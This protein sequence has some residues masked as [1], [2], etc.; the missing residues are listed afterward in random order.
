MSDDLQ[1]QTYFTALID[2]DA[3]VRIE[4]ANALGAMGD[5]RAVKP[6]LLALIDEEV[7]VRRAA[8]RALGKLGDDSAIMG[9]LN[10]FLDEDG[11]VRDTVDTVLDTLGGAGLNALVFAAL[12]HNE[13][14]IRR[15]A[16]ERLIHI[17]DE[18]AVLPLITALMDDDVEVQQLAADA[19][20][21]YD[22]SEA[23]TAIEEWR[24][25][26]NVN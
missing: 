24:A 1:L 19:L 23:R 10:A 26:R 25:S 5:V 12:K 21:H 11:T 6:L 3:D 17:H 14:A 13:P 4:A 8:V 20:S 18:R 22:T 9:L 2:D 15:H 16:I 7:T